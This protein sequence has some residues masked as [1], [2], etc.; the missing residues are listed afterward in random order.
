MTRFN[1]FI[2]ENMASV[3][4][5]IDKFSK[6]SS[7]KQNPT[8]IEEFNFE[9]E[10]ATLHRY[11]E[12][13]MAENENK[14]PEALGEIL[15]TI[16]TKQATQTH[17]DE[18]PATPPPSERPLSVV[19]ALAGDLP[20]PGSNGSP[21]VLRRPSHR[22]EMALSSPNSAREQPPPIPS[23]VNRP[24]VDAS[25][26]GSTASVE[27]ISTPIRPGVPLSTRASSLSGNVHPPLSSRAATPPFF[28]DTSA[29]ITSPLSAGMRSSVNGAASPSV[30]GGL[31]PLPPISQLKLSS[32]D[33]TSRD[34]PL[35][36]HAPSLA[37]NSKPTSA[38]EAAK[39]VFER[40][41]MFGGSVAGGDEIEKKRSM[42][43]RP[44]F[45]SK[46]LK[47]ASSLSVK[48]VSKEA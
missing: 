15:N 42:T 30:D 3:K 38:I 26:P 48:P 35:S 37:D 41:S 44:G 8:P 9:K 25:R 19:R 2:N 21:F 31:K 46:Q 34:S 27:H 6:R 4:Q 40:A 16:R 29:R 39:S 14:L 33:Q 11:F 32:P 10:V 17:Q 47:S 22:S 23:S 12:D 36:Q 18:K 43:L 28:P 1:D 7:T 24:R 45:L 13:F 20:A 5:S